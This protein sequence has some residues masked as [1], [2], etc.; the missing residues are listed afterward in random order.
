MKNYVRAALAT[1]TAILALGMFATSAS[2]APR[3]GTP[4]GAHWYIGSGNAYGEV[5]W[6]DWA[7]DDDMDVLTLDDDIFP[8]GFSVKMTVVH[9]SWKRTVHATY[10]E[11]EHVRI[12]GFTK[13]EKAKFK[14]CAWDNN[15][16]IKC[17]PWTTVTE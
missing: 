17:R 7:G 5:R 14:A 11:I 8:Q 16:E 15:I 1:G 9:D 13:G 3:A 10:G 4:D 12:P 6:D 2:A